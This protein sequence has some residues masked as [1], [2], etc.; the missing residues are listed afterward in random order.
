MTF[1]YGCLLDH[2]EEGEDPL[3]AWG[4]VDGG[5]SDEEVLERID[6]WLVTN[7]PLDDAEDV[8]EPEIVFI[9]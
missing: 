6:E 9:D 2:L 1:P 3:L 7:S 8:G 5:Y 4:V